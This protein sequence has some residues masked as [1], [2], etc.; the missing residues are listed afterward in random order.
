MAT[1]KPA[2]DAKIAT[3]FGVWSG[4]FVARVDE[5]TADVPIGV[6]TTAVV[7][8][9]AADV[10]IGVA[11]AVTDVL[12]TD[13]GTAVVLTASSDSVDVAQTWSVIVMMS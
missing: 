9:G 11:T 8:E 12:E 5:G 3:V 4:L 1:N 2:I 6:T 13:G 7:D 10:P